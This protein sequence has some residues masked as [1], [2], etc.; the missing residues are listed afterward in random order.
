MRDLLAQ[1][2]PM[3]DDDT[4]DPQLLK[5]S[6]E[7]KAAWIDFHD[8]VEV[9]LRPGRDLAEAR[10]VASKAADN[11]V[12]LAAL[13][14]LFEGDTG[15][16]IGVEYI[17]RGT[18]LVTWHLYEARRFLGEIALTKEVRD[19][20]RLDTW[21]LEQCRA[22][23]NNRVLRSTILTHGPGST[24][25]K[26]SLDA[27]LAELVEAGRIR[28]IKEGRQHIVEVN[29]TLLAGGDHGAA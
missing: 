3:T 27:A 1:P 15:H 18:A 25:N 10:D 26:R 8:Q 7:A 28:E 2:L 13:F 19:A 12:R 23:D 20:E 16:Y 9:E 14:H 6:P 21:L 24:R 22:K 17:D 5:L 29:P 4:L 11:V